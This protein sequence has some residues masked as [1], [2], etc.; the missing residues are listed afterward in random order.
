MINPSGNIFYKDH[1]DTIY[2]IEWATVGTVID[3]TIITMQPYVWGKPHEGYVLNG[4]L[5]RL[6]IVTVQ[7]QVLRVFDGGYEIVAEG[8][9]QYED[10]IQMNFPCETG[11]IDNFRYHLNCS[12]VDEV[13]CK[14]LEGPHW[15]DPDDPEDA[16][17][18]WGDLSPDGSSLDVTA[19][20]ELDI[21][22]WTDVWSY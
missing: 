8:S 22:E 12:V 11:P 2:R 10:F 1:Y 5:F 20:G 14:V 18:I 17:A 21:L 13:N 15:A 7:R 4:I 6:G 3:F 16:D 9:S 19:T